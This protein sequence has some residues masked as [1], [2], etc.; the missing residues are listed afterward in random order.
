VGNVLINQDLTPFSGRV[1]FDHLAKTAGQAV[2]QWLKNELGTAP[3][4][5]YTT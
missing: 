1:I 4:T 3:R 2:N 5:P